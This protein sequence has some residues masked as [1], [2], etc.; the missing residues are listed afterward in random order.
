LRSSRAW[1]VLTLTF[2][3]ASRIDWRLQIEEKLAIEGRNEPILANHSSKS[4]SQEVSVSKMKSMNGPKTSRCVDLPVF[5]IGGLEPMGNDVTITVGRES[6]GRHFRNDDTI[7][8][9]KIGNPW[10]GILCRMLTRFK[11]C[12]NRPSRRKGG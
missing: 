10:C 3:H 12:R 11:L 2:E 7:G 8:A 1:L 5:D 6:F 9:E 4:I